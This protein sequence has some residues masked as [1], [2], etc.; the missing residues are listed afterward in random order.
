MRDKRTHHESGSWRRREQARND[1]TA[2]GGQDTRGQSTLVGFLLLFGIVVLLVAAVQVGLVPDWNRAIEVEHNE[3]AIA[4][5]QDLS[6][7]IHRVGRDG[8][9]RSRTVELGTGY[10]T[11]PFLINPPDPSGQLRTTDPARFEL[12]NVDIGGVDNYAPTEAVIRG[13]TRRLVYEPEYNEHRAAPRTVYENGLLYNQRSGRA[14]LAQ[15]RFIEGNS[16]SL[17]AVQGEYDRTSTGTVTVPVSAESAPAQAVPVSSADG[18]PLA[19]S[20]PTRVPESGWERV[21]AGEFERNGGNIVGNES[22]VTVSD[23]SLTVTLAGDTEYE[24]Q[25]ARVAVGD[26]PVRTAPQYLTDIAGG[27]R[28]LAPGGSERLVFEVRDRFNNPRAGVPV[29]LDASGGSLSRTSATTGTDGRVSVRYT[30]PSSGGSQTVTATADIRPGPDPVAAEQASIGL[31]VVAGPGGGGG[32]GG[33]GGEFVPVNP[34]PGADQIAI[35]EVTRA[36]TGAD[37]RFR[38]QRST[39]VELQ[40]IRVPFY[41]TGAEGNVVVPRSG[42][43]SFDGSETGFDIPDDF[44]PVNGPTLAAEGQTGSEATVSFRD[45]RRNPRND[46]FV[47]HTI[48]TDTDGNRYTE[49]Y[50]INLQRR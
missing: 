16:I 41:Y 13:T 37:I 8:E 22:G 39:E 36:N 45:F 31:E 1:H 4:D 47:L 19:L 2:T 30:A 44:V 35:A 27:D 21:L 11:R 3:R 18:G 43:F 17:V 24:L 40:E 25:V 46:F 38:N 15:E 28:S 20:L 9:S 49:S 12:R 26:E 7:E 50:F 34:G 5:M 6:G 14:I 32:G 10:P 29:T 33:G 48:W 42:T 23:D